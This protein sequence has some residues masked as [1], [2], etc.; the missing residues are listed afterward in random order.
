MKGKL[1]LNRLIILAFL[2]FCMDKSLSQSGKTDSLKRAWLT[3]KDDT[4][5][6]GSLDAYAW[7]YK[8]NY[9]DSGIQLAKR[10]LELLKQANVHD[11][12][13]ETVAR[14]RLFYHLQVLNFMNGDNQ[15]AIKYSAQA[16]EIWEALWRGPAMGRKSE[17]NIYK[18]YCFGNL[19]NVYLTL[20]E[21]PVALDYYF[22]ALK[23]RED[24]ATICNIGVVYDKQ[25]DYTK[26]HTYY[27]KALKLDEKLNNKRGI[28][29]DLGNIGSACI[30]TGDYPKAIEYCSR[31]LKIDEELE[32]TA[33]VARH[34]QNLGSIHLLRSEY[35]AALDFF[36]KALNLNKR[37]GDQREISLNLGNI[38]NVYI[39][40]RDFVKAEKFLKDALEV[41][42][43]MRDKFIILNW[44]F[45]LSQMDSARGNYKG[46]YDYYKL[47]VLYNDSI[48]NE[49]NTK[50]Q[51]ETEMQYEFDKREAETKA[52]QEKKDAVLAEEKRRQNI[53]LWSAGC[54]LILMLAFAIFIFRSFRQKQ[55][56]NVEISK[57]KEVIEEKQKEILDSIYYARRIQ[58]SLLPNEKYITRVLTARTQRPT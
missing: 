24:A 8:Y 58:R 12:L 11:K 36:S 43:Q 40:K 45:N 38:G 15:E 51:T 23:I 48:S 55:K 31:A 37:L 14:G 19:G 20:G 39:Q 50:Q 7:E 33:G 41:S 22:R 13:W 26:A 56:A 34:L 6:I 54:G 28:S 52:A 35:A 47:Y 2:C 21:Y 42:V 32:N 4:G 27:L 46:A 10:A 16:L 49:E 53:I 57:Q 44:A 1:F 5:R 18:S 25:Q 3:A 9:P 30:N 17:F 29:R